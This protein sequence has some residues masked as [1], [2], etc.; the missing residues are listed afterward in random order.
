MPDAPIPPVTSEMASIS[1]CSTL[2][3]LL[4][5]LVGSLT[6]ELPQKVNVRQTLTQQIDYNP[7]VDHALSVTLHKP[8]RNM[9]FLI[10]TKN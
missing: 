7:L 3:S 5:D 4:G 6:N 9:V 8:N 1:P 2:R 10:E